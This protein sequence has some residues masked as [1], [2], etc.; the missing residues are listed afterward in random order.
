MT[1]ELA[2]IVQN[3]PWATKVTELE[4]ELAALPDTKRN[5]SKRSLLEG[6]IKIARSQAALRDCAQ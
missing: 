4:A 2:K 3:H 6:C 5:A 1:P